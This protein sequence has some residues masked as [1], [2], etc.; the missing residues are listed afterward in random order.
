MAAFPAARSATAWTGIRWWP[1]FQNIPSEYLETYYPMLVEGYSTIIGHRRRRQTPRRQR[2]GKN[3]SACSRKATSR[4]TTTGTQSQPWGILG[5]RPGACSEKWLVRK[6]GTRQ[7]LPSKVDNVRVRAGDRVLFRTAGG[8]GWGDPLERDIK[9]TRDDV[10]RRLM[11][12]TK[13][14][15][16]YGV[17]LTGSGLDI[18]RRATEEMRD[19]MRRNR[20]T[21]KLFDFGER[22]G[23]ASMTRAAHAG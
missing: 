2:R 8:G 4:S 23:N 20:K 11:S 10:A 21:P 12:E 5:G 1:L 19:S 3:L 13:A 17:V 18:D 6:D 22:K 15:E 16:E 9:R 14:R 7:P